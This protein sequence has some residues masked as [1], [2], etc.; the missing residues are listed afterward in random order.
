MMFAQSVPQGMQYQAV[1]RDLQGKVMANQT[2][3]LLIELVL[4]GNPKEKAYAETHQAITNELGLF[5]L[6]IGEGRTVSGTFTDIPWS[7]HEIWMQIGL[8]ENQDGQYKT[9]NSS[10]LLAVPYAFHSGSANKLAG[11]QDA[12]NRNGG[13]Y[14]HILGNANTNPIYT[15]LGTT[16]FKDLVIKTNNTEAMRI[17]ATGEVEISDDLSVG[18][19]ALI[20][21]DLDVANNAD[22]GND[23][24]VEGIARFNNTTQSTTKDDGS[25]IVEGGVGIEKNMN[26]GGDGK[27]TG[28][29]GVDGLTSLN[30]GLNVNN[31]SSTVLTGILNVN[32]AT[33]LDGTL[34]VDGL[35][36]LNSGLNVT[37]GL[38][39]LS[40]ALNVDGIATFNNQFTLDHTII[41]SQSDQTSYPMLIKGSEQGLAIQV[42][43]SW[44]NEFT[45]TGRGN[46]Y[47]S[48]WT[49]NS[50]MTGRIEGMTRA[51]LDPTGLLSLVG[52]LVSNP[53]D[54]IDLAPDFGSFLS[55][56]SLDNT[57][58]FFD[59]LGLS[60]LTGSSIVNPSS[61]SF[62][63]G[64]FSSNI[65][66]AISDPSSIFIDGFNGIT[67]G[68]TP[69]NALWTAIS[70]ELCDPNGI[71]VQG[72]GQEAV[73]NWKSQIFSNYTLDVLQ[74]GI[75]TIGNIITLVSSLA[76][77]LDP[78]D[79]FSEAVGV[80]VDVINLVIYGS[81]A[82]INIGVAYESGS[83]DYAEWLERAYAEEVINPGDVVGV[84][85]GKISKNFTH[86]DRFMAI[87]TAPIVLGN[88]PQEKEGEAFSEK[89]AFMGQVPVKV[90]G[91]VE[92]GDY[93]LP[94][95]LGDGIA[96]AVKPHQMKAR[97][98]Q[99]IVG[100]A[101][102]ASRPNQYIN[103]INT[104][105]GLNHNDMGRV[106]EEM[107]YTLNQLQIAMQEVNPDYKAR[108]YDVDE[109]VMASNLDF[110][111]SPSHP[112]M[113]SE[114]FEGKSYESQ[115]EMLEDVKKALQQE[116]GVS[117]EQ[118]PLVEYILD[119]PDKAGYLKSY[120][121]QIM[122]EM[123]AMRD[124]IQEELSKER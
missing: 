95:G 102:E 40:G 6:T 50:T 104:A 103:L 78:E 73:T 90:Q 41:G 33:D 89:V 74:G 42:T 68:T 81:Y 27:F 2:V 94:S 97:D 39:D 117:F 113:V 62:D 83:G 7:Q 118:V 10:R 88:M 25:V 19:N 101:W 55:L 80:L 28:A 56:P 119:N 23:L 86:A 31:G 17:T 92:I 32:M 8:D 3:H 36:V 37:S 44:S 12:E 22:I 21:N 79:I 43:K 48:F 107:Q 112:V 24:T 87:S 67:G 122:D 69:A 35:T 1:A 98:Y 121:Q 114:Y 66:G 38:T 64:S 13:I 57:S 58:S 11:D 120:Y 99:R 84:I 63:P 91:L 111:V 18:N 9:I 4:D 14:W 105:V 46:N 47:I 49:D 109:P 116:A 106:I 71:F 96:I 54:E 61:G 110:S 70:A 108:M 29:L 51:D 5:T 75:S 72:A 16:D 59:V 100:I 76:S 124:G 53:P 123:T 115:E 65:T 93:I 52:E 82:D 85:G 26:V 45:D 34:N 77:I 30:S 15:F 60:V 20:G